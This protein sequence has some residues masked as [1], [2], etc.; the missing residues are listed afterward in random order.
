MTTNAAGG[1]V[2]SL[3]D[4][5]LPAPLHNYSN[6]NRMH[7]ISLYG[8]HNLFAQSVARQFCSLTNVLMFFSLKCVTNIAGR[9]PFYYFFGLYAYSQFSAF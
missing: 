7:K 9:V 4:S 1:E 8:C 2:P 6:I 5:P 3:P